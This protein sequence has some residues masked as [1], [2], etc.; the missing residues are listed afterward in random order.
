MALV[1]AQITSS[2]MTFRGIFNGPQYSQ[3]AEGIGQGVA[4]WAVGNPS[5]LAF[6]GQATGILGAGTIAPATTRV[7]VS[8][9]PSKVLT[10]LSGAGYI[11]PN[12]SSLAMAVSQGLSL[13][14]TSFA[15]YA[16]ACAGVGEGVDASVIQ[17]SN[18]ASLGQILMGTLAGTLG[19]TGPAL[20]NLAVGLGIGI[21]LLLLGSTGTG[22]V[23]GVKGP[24][25]GVGMTNSVVV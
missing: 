17:V 21:S 15:Q 2:L 25:P 8:P 13:S 19:G 11:G 18:G 1:A 20:S 22:M 3:L 23:S 6:L 14:F 12:A 10:G 9:D 16:G 5:N 4:A 7:F 24:F